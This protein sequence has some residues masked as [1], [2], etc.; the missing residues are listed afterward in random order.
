MLSY[1]EHFLSL[2]IP[3]KKGIT[4]LQSLARFEKATKKKHP[5]LVSPKIDPAYLYLF[6]CF[7]QLDESRETIEN[8]IKF[9]EIDAWERVSDIK[10]SRYELQLIKQIDRHWI[11]TYRK[12]RPRDGC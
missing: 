2:R 6:D 8:P 5:G 9:T 3:D 11:T 7:L 10:L 4:K 1:V 12:L